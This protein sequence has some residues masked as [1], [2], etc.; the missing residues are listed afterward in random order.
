ML[1]GLSEWERES[2]FKAGSVA[3]EELYSLCVPVAHS[4]YESS[5]T[6][7]WFYHNIYTIALS[8]RLHRA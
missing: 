7:T 6:T 8:N 4:M 5:L 1:V 2:A 3:K